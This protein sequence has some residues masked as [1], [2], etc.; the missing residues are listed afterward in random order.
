MNEQ[1]EEEPLLPW[2]SKINQPRTRSSYT[3]HIVI[4]A[5]AQSITDPRSSIASPAWDF[6]PSRSRF[7]GCGRRGRMCAR[8]AP[9]QAITCTAGWTDVRG[10]WKR[11][12]E[13]IKL[14]RYSCH[15][16]STRL[17]SCLMQRKLCFGPNCIFL[18]RTS[19]ISVTLW[20]C[21]VADA[22]YHAIYFLPTNLSISWRF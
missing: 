14:H 8:G 1:E 19:R 2:I 21:I 15:I 11:R 12:R 5:A 20:F 16:T 18:K 13:P 6:R 22:L 3:G 9:G 17:A 7:A 4:A 10:D